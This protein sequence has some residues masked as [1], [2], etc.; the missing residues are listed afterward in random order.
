MNILNPPK[1]YVDY[2]CYIHGLSGLEL[3]NS[4]EKFYKKNSEYRGEISRFFN[5][6]DDARQTSSL[7]FE[8]IE[9]RGTDGKKRGKVVSA[10]IYDIEYW[11]EGGSI[12]QRKVY[13]ANQ[14]K[15]S[16]ERPATD[17]EPGEEG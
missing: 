6:L 16:G 17:R 10:M 9:I 7:P 5:Y 15:F 12:K 14:G 8:K 3:S 4:Q 11:V 1:S 2:R 13:T